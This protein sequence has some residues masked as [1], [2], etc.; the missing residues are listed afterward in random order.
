MIP[1]FHALGAAWLAFLF[2]PLV[3]FYFL[4]LK[5]QRQEVPSLLLWRQ[6]LQDHRVNSPFQRFKRNI[7]LFLQL[8][9]LLLLVLAAMQPYWRGQ[10]DS[11]RRLPI[12]IDTSASMGALDKAGGMSRLDAAR[13]QAQ[14][15]IDNLA[16]DQ[17]VCLISFG[18]T[19]RKLTDFTS[20]KRILREALDALVVQDVPSNVE[21]GLRIA[22]A[23]ARSTPFEQA[24]LLSDGNFPMPDRFDLP[25]KLDYRR[26]PAAGT[27]LGITGLVAQRTG[28]EGWSLF[29]SIE[30]SS[31]SAAGAA[32]ELLRDGQ[33]LQTTDVSVSRTKAERLAFK[34]TLDKP[35]SFEVR[36]KPDGFDAL[37]ADNVAFIDLAPVRPVFVYAA[38]ECLAARAALS[39]QP[40]VRLFPEQGK[41]STSET[42]F[43]LVITNR[44]ADASLAAPVV[45]FMGPV[46]EDL[47]PLVHFAEP[48]TT[49]IDWSRTAPLLAHVELTDLLVLH[50][51]QVAANVRDNDFENLS[52]EA[53]A[54]GQHGP[55]I[56]QKRDASRIAYFILFKPEESTFPYRVGFPVM[57]ANLVQQAMQQAGLAETQGQTTGVL[58]PLSLLPE[59]TYTIQSPDGQTWTERSDPRGTLAGVPAN[60]VGRYRVAGNGST[61]RSVGVGLL[62]AS[63]TS[64]AGADQIRFAETSVKAESTAT[65]KVDRAYWPWLAALALGLLMVEW[66]FY[67]RRPGGYAA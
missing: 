4:K 60:R 20:N 61:G 31:E 57:L 65:L 41:D 43:D 15:I 44:L 9:L 10:A 37:P 11:I 30:S 27:N 50:G 12:L 33:T 63:E 42:H 34:F 14:L 22:Q 21:D 39:V 5:R 2:I 56:L 51:P 45:A 24:M 26:L 1:G 23:L 64:L 19:G 52:Y 55:L 54:Y 36:L 38:P 18:R 7:L 3:I 53:L 62:N 47:K 13:Q 46:P 67:Q 66:W 40:G 29:V 58:P 28:Q 8:L 59:S 6:V 35:S 49:A 25:F 32:V 48:A 16:S 17:E